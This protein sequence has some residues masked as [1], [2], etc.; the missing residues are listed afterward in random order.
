MLW[1]K[2]AGSEETTSRDRQQLREREREREVARTLLFV[3]LKFESHV[4]LKV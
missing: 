3:F 1:L 2:V 4:M